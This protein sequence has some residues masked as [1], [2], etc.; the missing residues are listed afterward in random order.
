MGGATAFEF[1]SQHGHDLSPEDLDLFE[2]DVERQA[3]VVHEEQL[4]LVVAG[5]VREAERAFDDLLG[6]A[7]GQRCH[8]R[9]V[10]ERRAVTVDGSVVEIGTE[11][12]LRLGLGPR[13][14][15]LAAEPDDGLVCGAVTVLLE[16][17]PIEGDHL[18]D[19]F[20]VPE[21]V[22]VEEA[23]AVEGGLLGDLGRTDGAV[24]DEGRGVVERPRGGG[25]A[26]QRCAE[27]A[28]PVDDAF[29][30]E[31]SQQVVVLDGERDAL[32]DVL[33]EPR[34]DR[35]GVPASHHEVDAAAG[36]VL[37]HREVL[38]DLHRVV[39]GDEGGRGREDE[40]LGP[41]GDPAEHRRRRGRDE[42]WIVVLAGREDVQTHLLG[43]QR[44]LRHR[45]DALVFGGD[46]ARRGVARD[47]AD[48]E[49]AELHGRTSVK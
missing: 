40:L 27:L 30:P 3:G 42:G 44:D 45:D 48:G 36:E 25:V 8:R 16:P 38:G 37:Q 39:G 12:P 19:V 33:A 22:V 31:P 24:P 49:D 28:L 10:L 46:P 4:T 11:D 41:R 17:L 21:D 43:L 18:L 6:C 29:A 14:E 1:R 35:S 20:L 2:H 9:E 34:V 5:V 47:V 26:V 23:V 15:H 32:P 13:H 7:D